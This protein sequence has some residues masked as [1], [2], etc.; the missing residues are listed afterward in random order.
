MKKVSDQ[1]SGTKNLK[2]F[3]QRPDALM[4][5]E[6]ALAKIVLYIVHRD[7]TRL[8]LTNFENLQ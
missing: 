2:N 1:R 8:I 4:S 5:E 3:V 6:Y 7:E